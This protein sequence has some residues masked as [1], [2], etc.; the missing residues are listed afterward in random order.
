MVYGFFGGFSG[1]GD[2]AL[3]QTKIHVVVK[4]QTGTHGLGKAGNDFPHKAGTAKTDVYPLGEVS[5]ELAGIFLFGVERGQEMAVVLQASEAAANAAA[6]EVLLELR[7]EL[8][9]DL[10][11]SGAH[12]PDR[13][14]P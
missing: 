6:H 11:G 9:G 14:S 7:E 4:S 5:G 10:S 1:Q 12:R 8:V 3:G 13:N 2:H